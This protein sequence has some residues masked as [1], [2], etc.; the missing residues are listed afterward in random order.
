[1]NEEKKAGYLMLLPSLA[2]MA[3]IAFFPILWALW[4]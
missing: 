3:A 2:V 1:M 4:L